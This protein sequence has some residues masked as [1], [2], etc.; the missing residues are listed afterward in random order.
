MKITII[1]D[2]TQSELKTEEAIKIISPDKSET[3]YFE[4]EEINALI[5]ELNSG[6]ISLTYLAQQ[7]NLSGYQIHYII[8][9]LLKTG[10]IK[11]ELTY[12]TFTSNKA[13]KL[14]LVQKAKAHKKEHIRKIAHKQP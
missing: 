12:N 4:Q 11:G 3:I 1:K 8:G 13:S 2:K 9:N 6:K 10:Q 7:L 5:A 14:L